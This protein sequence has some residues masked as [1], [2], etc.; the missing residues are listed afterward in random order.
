M[1]IRGHI[2][3][4]TVCPNAVDTTDAYQFCLC[5]F[6]ESTSM[7]HSTRAQMYSV[8]FRSLVDMG[9]SP[10]GHKKI[11]GRRTYAQILHIHKLKMKFT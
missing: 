10:H 1:H 8:A 2:R 4:Y 7:T 5:Y 11:G 9:T 6:M 3:Q